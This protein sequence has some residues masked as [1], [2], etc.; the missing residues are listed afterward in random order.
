M[1]ELKDT[2]C[3]KYGNSLGATCDVKVGEYPTIFKAKV[4]KR[5]DGIYL[6]GNGIDDILRRFGVKRDWYIVFNYKEGSLF[7]LTIYDDNAQKA[8]YPPIIPE[9]IKED[10][11]I[12]TDTHLEEVNDSF[13]VTIRPSFVKK[14][15]YLAGILLY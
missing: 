7:T 1:Q 5:N 10:D 13:S 6:G 15:C 11:D 12:S 2:F 8:P 9:K 14:E 4:I 3:Q